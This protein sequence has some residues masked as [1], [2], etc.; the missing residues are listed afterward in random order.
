MRNHNKIQAIGI[1]GRDP[2]MRFTPSGAP[3]TNFS[4]AVN[5]DYKTKEGETVK[6][7][8]WYKIVAW[9]KLAE[10][11]N[12]YLKKGSKVFVEGKLSLTNGEP[13]VWQNKAGEWHASVEIQAMELEMLGGG[14]KTESGPNMD[15]PPVIESDDGDLP[16]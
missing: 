13:K 6:Q 11:C 1:L 14:E 15:T 8:Y 5:D 2:E 9:N 10:I 12:Q 3:V 16:F 4:I 7:T